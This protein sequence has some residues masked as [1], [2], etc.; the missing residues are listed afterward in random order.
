[1]LFPVQAEE[2]L[3]HDCILTIEQVCLSRVDLKD[4]PF[5]TPDQTLYTAGNSFVIRGECKSG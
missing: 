3:E 2:N 1:V 4:V 5:E